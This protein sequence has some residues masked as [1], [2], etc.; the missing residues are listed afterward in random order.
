VDRRSFVVSAAALVVTPKALARSFDRMPLALVT[1]D[2]ES[3]VAVVQLP[4][5]KVL[6]RIRTIAGPRSIER[7]GESAVVAHT[8][9]G[10]VSVLE[11]RSL[12]IRTVLHSFDEPRY[13]TALPGGRY[14]AVS[15]SAAGSVVVLDVLR[16][17]VVGKAHIGGPARHISIDRSGQT[18]WVSLGTKAARIAAVDVKVP[19][20]PRLLGKI[21]PPFLAHDV[22]FAPRG[23]RIWV[24]SGDRKELALFDPRTARVVT[25]LAAGAPPQHVTFAGSHAFVT[26]GEDG[27]LDTPDVRSGRRIRSAAVPVGSYNVQEDWG[28]VLSPSLDRGTL[29]IADR[30]GKVLKRIRVARSSHDACFVMSPKEK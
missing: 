2:L 21:K 3:H 4:D 29:A 24:T 13:T 8:A 10:A 26:S 15:D 19:T 6:R 12:S 1:A 20:R 9:H 14:A 5:G 30:R 18:I 28:L 23:G 25:R 7:V 16:G 27:T 22:G 11:G 17:R